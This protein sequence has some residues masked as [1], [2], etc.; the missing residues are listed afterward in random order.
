[1]ITPYHSGG[2]LLSYKCNSRCRHCLYGCSS[3]WRKWLS[4]DDARKILEGIRC[5]SGQMQHGIHLAGG[6][7]FLDFP[8][9]LAIQRIAVEH[10][11]PVQYVETNAGWCVN[12]SDTKQKFSLLKN[13][14]LNAI[15]ISS[16]P[17]HAEYIPVK[18]VLT[19][20]KAALEVFG[21]EGVLIW[22]PQFLQQFATLDSENTVP[23]DEYLDAVGID[24]AR[25]IISNGYSMIGGGR[26]GATIANFF[27]LSPP[28]H[29]FQHKCDD[30]LFRSGH[31]H[32][33]PWG[34][35][36]PSFC[37]GISLGD[38]RNLPHLMKNL[39]INRL[40]LVKMLAQDGLGELYNMACRD[41]DYDPE[42]DGYIDKCHLCVSIR[43]HIASRTTRFKELAPLEFYNQIHGEKWEAPD[44]VSSMALI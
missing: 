25:H 16:S 24:T 17:F 27:H 34:N 2:I 14:G 33:D 20:V 19:A 32:F 11:V 36:I 43:K 21:P 44:A 30:D 39:D 37:S 10:C 8:R 29:F 13:A 4:V 23:F 26:A 15:L 35:L 1:M 7:P 5:A 38:A 28:E 40:P 3:K 41:F 42:P 9:L 18:R 31:A 12:E 6:E 22:V